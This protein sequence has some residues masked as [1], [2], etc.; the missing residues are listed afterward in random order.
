MDI[1]FQFDA[2]TDGKALN[3]I[4]V[5]KVVPVHPCGS[6]DADGV[7]AA[8]DGIVAERGVPVYIRMDNEPEVTSHALEDWDKEMGATL[9][10]IDSGSP[11]HQRKVRVAQL[12]I[13]R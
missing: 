1:D 6:I 11:W 3:I 10:S 4:D 7:I 13:N 5:I 12:E 8:L 9:Y 2:T